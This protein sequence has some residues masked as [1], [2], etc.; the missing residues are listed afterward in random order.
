MLS[1]E[2]LVSL[3][4]FFRTS[5]IKFYRNSQRMSDSFYYIN[6]SSELHLKNKVLKYTHLAMLWN[7][8]VKRRHDVNI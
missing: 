4:A 7:F 2:P 5:L 1:S 3:I 6:E 8:C